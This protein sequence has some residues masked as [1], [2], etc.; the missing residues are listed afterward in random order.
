MPTF[1]SRPDDDIDAV[2]DAFAPIDID[3]DSD[4]L[5]LT[6]ER[7][8]ITEEAI[9][10][11]AA[12]TENAP[13]STSE[14]RRR[15]PTTTSTETPTAAFTTVGISSTPNTLSDS[16]TRISD[17]GNTSGGS[18]ATSPSPVDGDGIYLAAVSSPRPF[19][20]AKRTRR[21][22]VVSTTTTT[23]TT[24]ATEE[25]DKVS[26]SG[27]VVHSA[28]SSSTGVNKKHALGS[29]LSVRSHA[30]GAQKNGQGIDA[31]LTSS[32]DP[33]QQVS[34]ETNI[35]ATKR[36]SSSRIRTRPNTRFGGAAETPA[37]ASSFESDD[38]SV[39]KPIRKVY[40]SRPNRFRTTESSEVGAVESDDEP[41]PV[42]QSSIVARPNRFRLQENQPSTSTESASS[43]DD[44]PQPSTR[45]VPR[46]RFRP[47]FD[48][49][50]FNNEF[51]GGLETTTK[52]V[53]RLL[54]PEIGNDLSSLT[55]ADFG[56]S[57]GNTSKSPSRRIWPNRT[58]G[59]K[60]P[61]AS[62]TP[63]VY[64]E[65]YED[66]AE[67]SSTSRPFFR[68]TASNGVRARLPLGR[69]SSTTETTA[70]TTTPTTRSSISALFR[71]KPFLFGRTTS[72]EST[73]DETE[74]DDDETGND[75]DSTTIA[76]DSQGASALRNYN[77]IDSNIVAAPNHLE[78]E[79]SS[80]ERVR[81]R[82]SKYTDS[83]IFFLK[84]GRTTVLPL[85]E[86]LL[87]LNTLSQ[88]GNVEQID[89]ES[90]FTGTE[91]GQVV[92]ELNTTPLYSSDEDLDGV[93]TSSPA[94]TYSLATA[95]AADEVVLATVA[96][97]APLRRPL[98]R[99]TASPALSVADE[100][101]ELD[102]ATV[103]STRRPS[104]RTTSSPDST[105][106]SQSDV[107]SSS[108]IRGRRPLL[109]T[110]TTTEAAAEKA[111]DDEATVDSIIRK[112]PSFR[113]PART[114]P[115]IGEVIIEEEN[116]QEIT[117]NQVRQQSSFT[118][119]QFRTRTTPKQVEEN[120]Q[121]AEV[122]RSN[123]VH[124]DNEVRQR[125]SPNRRPFGNR[126]TPKP[127]SETHVQHDEQVETIRSVVRRPSYR[128]PIATSTST[129]TEPSNEEED[130]ISQ[131][132]EAVDLRRNRYNSKRFQTNRISSTTEGVEESTV[133]LR[134]P[135]NRVLYTRPTT[136]QP[137]TAELDDDVNTV[138]IT[139]E[140]STGVDEEA[141]TVIAEESQTELPPVQ[142]EKPKRRRKVIRRRKP[143]SVSMD[144]VDAITV[145]NDESQTVTEPSAILNLD[146]G[147]S[148]TITTIDEFTL[149]EVSSLDVDQSSTSITE[150]NETVVSTELTS[151]VSTRPSIRPQLQR[152]TTTESSIGHDEVV[153]PDQPNTTNIE[154]LPVRGYFRTPA[155][156]NNEEE[157][158]TSTLRQSKGFSPSIR[159]RK[160]PES[161]QE[162]IAT[163]S[164][165]I[166]D[167]AA[168]G[169][170]SVNLIEHNDAGSD[171]LPSKT[172]TIRPLF[173]RQGAA[174]RT[175]FR[176]TRPT[177]AV[178]F[179]TQTL[180]TTPRSYIRKFSTSK[181]N[182]FLL[183]NRPVVSENA[184]SSDLL[185]RVKP[186]GFAA[187][188]PTAINRFRNTYK[189]L[190][191]G[192]DG[193][194]D[195]EEYVNSGEQQQ[196]NDE[197]E[198]EEFH[199][200]VN[201]DESSIPS[202]RPQRPTFL[203]PAK[204]P[205]YNNRFNLNREEPALVVPKIRPSLLAATAPSHAET[206]EEIQ[207]E[208]E[209]IPEQPL[210]PFNRFSPSTQRPAS[211]AAVNRPKYVARPQ[212]KVQN[213]PVRKQNVPYAA[214][215]ST[216]G[217]A[218]ADGTD[219]LADL[220]RNALNTRNKAIFQ[221]N[222]KKHYSNT[223]Q[224]HL[225][226]SNNPNTATAST[227][228]NA[229]TS[230]TFTT[231]TESP[232]QFSTTSTDTITTTESYTD[233]FMTTD[234]DD[235]D[236]VDD[237]TTSTPTFGQLLV[238]TL[239]GG[240][241]AT[242]KDDDDQTNAIN[243]NEFQDDAYTT[244]SPSLTTTEGATSTIGTNPDSDT[245]T[246]DDGGYT[247]TYRPRFVRPTAA[248][249]TTSTTTQ[250]PT[251][252]H[253]IFAVDYDEQTEATVTMATVDPLASTTV[254]PATTITP[255]PPA[256]TAEPAAELITQKLEKLA[257]VSRI[258]EIS[259]HDRRSPDSEVVIEKLP[260]VE[261]LGEI[262]R[263][264]L[265][266]LV[267]NQI[268]A[269]RTERREHRQLVWPEQI[270]SVETSTIPLEALFERDR[271][272]KQLDLDAAVL[273]LG[274]AT[275]TTETAAPATNTEAPAVQVHSL[276]PQQ[277]RSESTNESIPLVISIANLDQVVISKQPPV[278]DVD[279]DDDQVTMAAP[280]KVSVV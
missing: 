84:P 38:V 76:N 163:D 2:S 229:T 255:P 135:V 175:P 17:K 248:A 107:T 74:E 264:T 241:D 273:G 240:A 137:T 27:V 14:P 87:A 167:E 115:S 231:S 257:E 19:A 209:P 159:L 80:S 26:P 253:H 207:N 123:E 118:Q 154:V 278:D 122:E 9:V 168:D 156:A 195:D 45:T 187:Q 1:T 188:R 23:T 244:T 106:F 97:R 178:Q 127:P 151:T 22:F 275:T 126:S 124:Q 18:S 139:T 141:T 218:I 201:N 214:R 222:N 271:A 224:Q 246:T 233:T 54:R 190:D 160:R 88:D 30:L 71:P 217:P 185:G 134:T 194:Y 121:T 238:E 252:L 32:D 145:S 176:P 21:P 91:S 132:K 211:I 199:E 169:G 180:A 70:E 47:R 155:T 260:T 166:L 236:D 7:P 50:T 242:D 161:I 98:F 63:I 148:T 172:A 200:H 171:P 82:G 165:E 227:E 250:K 270:F 210:R 272:A 142:E 143:V 219:Q 79:S 274:R 48:G 267:E 136:A 67:F 213:S 186:F 44:Q 56:R 86:P 266:K 157:S 144:S 208:E 101:I 40:A 182:K 75:N 46:R 177:P 90:Q 43:V 153:R 41:E 228:T 6:T 78:T 150:I 42:R 12:P 152:R 10:A 120:E 206:A 4:P 31:S 254:Q 192:N 232:P 110:T 58:R 174:S 130:V 119:R 52:Y 129:T 11:A 262:S 36:P 55:A 66:R 249:S 28:A 102:L 20:F 5:T 15:R 221:A 85:L 205:T 109:R 216:P 51:G 277:F 247:T 105:S 64:D 128:R 149:T 279:V 29:L 94:S 108:S 269:L 133:T 68:P 223:P 256:D 113:L 181:K 60:A 263:L 3:L 140:Y 24:E 189:N 35:E 77:H 203:A 184:G 198:D 57:V 72:T 53:E 33:N 265:I 268:D 65:V 37:Q 116:V 204:R 215:T 234:G 49:A 138:L 89:S 13:L 164:T 125:P 25:S 212:T 158:E 104:F 39:V 16:P 245:T 170:L 8:T 197:E 62:T 93:T 237:H 243:L 112:R 225:T 276:A 83:P 179:T 61:T 114:T 96:P 103:T 173:S 100:A 59:T 69:T 258:V 92:F 235:D 34:V 191:D 226:N 95:D 239:F 220:D 99:T 146:I 251:T 111:G 81:Q 259:S 147:D 261:S 117:S 230:N 183:P 202:S 196:F 280:V 193:D 162:H 73:I 131:N